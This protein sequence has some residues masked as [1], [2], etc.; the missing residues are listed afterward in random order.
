MYKQIEWKKNKR[1]VRFTDQLMIETGHDITE[2][3]KD[4]N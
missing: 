4:R 2:I 1:L 3:S